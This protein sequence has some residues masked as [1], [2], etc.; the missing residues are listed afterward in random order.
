[1]KIVR[2]PETLPA[3]LRGS[4]IALGNFDG[5]HLGHQAVA[6][7]ARRIAREASVPFA[8]FTTEPHPRRYFRPAD[9]PFRLTPFRERACLLADFGVDLLV[10]MRFDARLASRPPRDFVADILV[11]KLGVSHV[12]T[13]Y[14]YRFGKGRAGDTALL[15]DLGKDLGFALT[16]VAPVG[17]GGAEPVIYSSSRIRAHLAAGEPRDAA[18]LLG[19]PFTISG[20]VISGDKRGR[21]IGFPTAN[22]AL[23]ETIRPRGGV[24]AVHVEIEGE[25]TPRTGVANI[26]RRPTFDSTGTLLEVHLFD[27]AGDLY[28]RHLRVALI[29]MLREE[30]KFDG[31][32]ALRQQ[33]SADCVAA[34]AVLARIGEA[35]R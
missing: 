13:G 5:F 23:G 10:S 32:E 33:I 25:A 34:R 27:F 7:R 15:A 4:A 11:E 8:I 24:Y 35:C 31:I 12:V 16:V 26:G 18:R 28:G 29:D 3:A 22:M 6:D 2:H 30:R 14:D 1:M 20:R 21:A 17:T 19:R 9:P